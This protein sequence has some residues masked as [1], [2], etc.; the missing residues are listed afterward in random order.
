MI[1]LIVRGK[2]FPF[3]ENRESPSWG[4][5]V[6][7]WA[8]EVSDALNSIVAT[9]DIAPTSAAILNDQSAPHDV[10][11]LQFESSTIRGAIVDYS[12]Y[13]TSGSGDSFI[14][15]VETGSMFLANKSGAGEWVTSV[16]G[17]ESANI[18]FTTDTDGQVQYTTD[19][20]DDTEYTGTIRFRARAIDYIV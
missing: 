3:P 9:G 10:L 14:E 12:V 5:Q 11:G 8:I 19:A 13:R 1:D 7:D 4:E 17:S 18:V 6:T 15:V 16:L 20:M 2:S